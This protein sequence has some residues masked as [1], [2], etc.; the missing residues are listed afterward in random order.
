MET[1]HFWR[2]QMAQLKPAPKGFRWLF[3]KKIHHK[4]GRI[5]YAET[6][7][8]EAFRFLVPCR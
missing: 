5:L 8:K 7:G 4:C 1:Q 6:Y 2:K 3:V